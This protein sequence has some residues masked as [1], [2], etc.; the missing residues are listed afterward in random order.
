MR[1]SM[2]KNLSTIFVVGGLVHFTQWVVVFNL[3]C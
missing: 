2:E 3:I 1:C